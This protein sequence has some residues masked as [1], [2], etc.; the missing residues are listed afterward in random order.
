MDALRFLACFLFRSSVVKTTSVHVQPK[1]TSQ[2]GLSNE[3]TTIGPETCGSFSSG[4]LTEHHWTA[5]LLCLHKY[6]AK[7]R[8]YA[9]EMGSSSTVAPLVTQVAHT[10]DART[11]TGTASQKTIFLYMCVPLEA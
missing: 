1:S 5:N 9:V 2:C 11:S 8:A 7:G 4:C 10:L 6:A 3:I